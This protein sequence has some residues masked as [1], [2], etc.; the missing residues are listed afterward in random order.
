MFYI[1]VSSDSCEIVWRKVSLQNGSSLA[2]GAFYRPLG[3]S[4]AEP[5]FEINI[6]LSLDATYLLLARDFNLPN[7]QWSD[8]LPKF[9]TT[10]LLYTAFREFID[11]H[12]LFQFVHTPI[13]IESNSENVLD[14]LFSND[15]D[16]VSSAVTAPGISDHEVV[17]ANLSSAGA[18]RCIF[19]PRKVFFDERGDYCSISHVLGTFFPRIPVPLHICDINTARNVFKAK[20]LSLINTFIPSLIISAKRRSD[21]R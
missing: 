7:V 12:L 11:A 19:Q 18:R 17:M 4:S 2:V 1:N 15:H 21:K 13:R 3:M 16:R 6:L 8:S 10:Y 20:L 14:L 9:A 5:I